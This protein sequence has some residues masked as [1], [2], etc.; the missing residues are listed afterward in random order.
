[1]AARSAAFFDLDNTM[2]RGSTL[3]FLGR[4]MY[5]RGYFS[6]S[7]ISKFVVAN[8][9]F[10]LTG[11]EKPEVIARFQKAATDFV[12]GHKLDELYVIAQSVYDEYV[13]PALIQG[14]I[15]L[16]KKHLSEGTEVWLVTAAPQDMAKLI[17]DRLGFTGALG[18]KAII[19]NGIFTG[20]LDGKILHGSEKARA[21][22]ELAAERGF[23]LNNCHA[24]SDSASDLPLLQSVGI[25]HAINP[26]ARLRIKALAEGWQMHDF[27]KFRKLN[28]WLGPAVSRVVA[29]GA[30]ITPRSKGDRKGD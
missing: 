19:E 14:T 4:A 16:A 2:V 26:D 23:S 10:R 5:K 30:W 25:P 27:R 17:A 6:R 18:T 24:Y 21:V 9:R 20:R 7:D 29:L 28:R 8:V 3:Y 1:M 12:G 15:D 11:T 13:S 22:R